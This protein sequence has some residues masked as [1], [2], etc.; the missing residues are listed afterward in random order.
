MSYTLRVLRNAVILGLVAGIIVAMSN[1]IAYL[2]VY[3]PAI[4]VP[5][6]VITMTI[7]LIFLSW[8]LT[9]K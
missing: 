3:Y 7:L 5:L 9:D 1:G 8:L 2:S 4:G 6:A